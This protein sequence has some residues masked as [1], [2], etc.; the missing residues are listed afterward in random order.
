MRIR[1]FPLFNHAKTLKLKTSLLLLALSIFGLIAWHNFNQSLNVQ[2]KTY[3]ADTI[4]VTYKE[5]IDFEQKAALDDFW[6]TSTEIMSTLGDSEVSEIIAENIDIEQINTKVIKVPAGLSVEDMLEIY[7]QNPNVEAVEPDYY[8]KLDRVPNDPNYN[9]MSLGLTIAGAQKGWDYTVGSRD[10]VVAIVDS[11]VNVN[12]PDLQANMM[13]TGYSVISGMSYNVDSTGHGTGVAGTV[14]TVGNNGI[15]GVGINWEV[16]I[17]PVKIS[18]ASTFPMSNVVQGVLWAADN[19]ADIINMSLGS[20]AGSTSLKN[21][22]D[23]AY[24]KGVLLV[25]ASGNGGKEQAHYPAYYDNVMSVGGSPNGGTSGFGDWGE[26][27]NVLASTSYNTT[28]MNGGYSAMSGTSFASPQ[29][30][31]LAAL[32]KAYSPSLTNQQLQYYIEKGANSPFGSERTKVFGYGYY[33][34]Y[35]SLNLLAADMGRD[36][37]ANYP[38]ITDVTITAPMGQTTTFQLTGTGGNGT[39]SF[40]GAKSVSKDSQTAPSV[41]T[42]SVSSSGL[43]TITSPKEPGEFWVSITI[44]S[45]GLRNHKAVKVIATG[46]VEELGIATASLPAGETGKIYNSFE[47][48]AT[49]GNLPYTWSATDLPSGLSFTST[50]RLYGTPTAAGTFN[51]NFTVRDNAGKTASK[52]ISITISTSGLVTP[53]TANLTYTIPTGVIYNA[54]P[55][56]IT[57]PAPASGV[58]GLGAITVRYAGTGGTT[59]PES[60]T[61]PTNAG[62]YT[63]YAD[64]AEGTGYNAA[65]LTLGAYTIEKK[66]ISLSG[67]TV[68]AKTYDTTTTA[69]VTAA[70]FTGL[71][72]SQTLALDVDYTVSGAVFNSAD[73]GTGRTITGTVALIANSKTANYTLSSGALSIG[74]QTIAKKTINI[75]G[76]VVAPKVYD[77]TTTATVT[78]VSFS[79]LV[80]GQT[81]AISVDYTIASA[82]YDSPSVGSGK[83][84]TATVA[85]L[86]NAKANN[87]TLSPSG[88]GNLSIS[89][90]TI[91]ALPTP[92]TTQISYAI[93]TGIV[94]NASP[95]PITAPV[96]ASGVVG[97]GAITV[98]YA[99]TGGTTYPESTAAPTDAG[100]YNVYADI[101][102]GD[103]YN[104]AKLNL[105]VY[106]I[107]KKAIGLSGGTVASKTYNANTNANITAVSFTGLEGGQSLNLDDDYTI[108]DAEFNSADAGS[109]KTVTGTVALIANSKTANYT[110]SSGALSIGSQTIS[111]RNISISGATVAPKVYDSTTDADITAVSFSGLA[112]SQTLNLT[113]D[114]TVSGAAYDNADV[115]TS[116]PVTATVSLVIN[117]KTNNYNLSYGD[118]STTGNIIRPIPTTDE[119]DFTIPTGIIYNA[120]P[121]PITTPTPSDG[122]IGLGAITVKYAGA[123]S[124]I[125][126]ESATAPTDAGDYT[127]YADIAEGVNYSAV[128]LNLGAYTINQKTISISTVSVTPKIYDGTTAANI[129]SVSFSGLEGG[130]TLSIITDYSIV[131][132]QFND[133][134]AGPGR[135]VTGAV[136]LIANS[137]TANYTLSSGALS[138]GSQTIAK[139]PI[140]SVGQEFNVK[141]GF[142]SIYS[143]DLLTLLPSELAESDVSAFRIESISEDIYT[144]PPSI[145]GHTL[146]LPVA[147]TDAGDAQSIITIGFTSSN[148]DI[149]EAIISVN[150]TERSPVEIT[151][152][153]VNSRAYNGSPATITGTP[154]F[155]DTMS[156]TT[157][158][159]LAP[160]YT[161]KTSTDSVLGVAPTDAGNY[162]LVVSADGS[163]DYDVADLEISFTISKAN[164]T[165]TFTCPSSGQI[166]SAITLTASISSGLAGITFSSA[167]PAIATVSGN[168]LSLLD[169]GTVTI[170]AS[171]PGNSNI[172]AATST[173]SINVVIPGYGVIQHFADFDGTGHR[174]AIINADFIEFVR[175]IYEGEEL[176]LDHYTVSEGS[177]VITLHDT[178]LSTLTTGTHTFLAEFSNGSIV[179]LGIVILAGTDIGVPNTGI[180]G[181]LLGGGYLSTGLTLAVVAVISV[182]IFR[183]HLNL[184]RRRI[185]F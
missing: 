58:T 174:T 24:G 171:H 173:C 115:G 146:S 122:V 35:K 27:L 183:R 90:Q 110:L 116:K 30:A 74:S 12:H 16:S 76:G 128:K 87:Y 91:T 147:N 141:S 114:Y 140:F 28:N 150:V 57:T 123:G 167:N 138:I 157:I 163:G 139:A 101:A 38:D 6:Y 104:S 79:G 23:Y 73:A 9:S 83:T 93:P 108:S 96:P 143:F 22:M 165:I 84:V 162:K 103:N 178:F 19:G 49:G 82:T 153:S 56:P 129:S 180:I 37:L 99:G 59:Y 155:T 125:Y 149:T 152:V 70:S 39:Y 161:W 105:G 120:S 113:T 135:T 26:K 156:R 50:G 10:V 88:S 130:Q 107:E 48:T 80:G 17:L 166:N 69:S 133:A 126:P 32:L 14:G 65:K 55:R 136:A 179:P 61:A 112:G 181:F 46:T 106:T 7:S 8:M 15:G 124:T 119:I 185:R 98:H 78:A 43:L 127:V 62:S 13:P 94:Y 89:G 85:L 63:V 148:Y 2:A 31:G 100:N 20:S 42:P 33:D 164:Q 159:T 137:K 160:I 154:I 36:Q 111:K 4:L 44:A 18:S 169:T 21:A 75:S 64:I 54:S 86:S 118:L 95:R 176:H 45:D 34:I 182:A 145:S 1:R 60:A 53:T 77:G 67:G 3:S 177:T 142:V 71:V 25:A 168:T 184:R 134:N 5:G 52:T 170:T 97:L 117:S 29:I 11:G 72:G 40:S 41:I 47:I 102:V 81:L 51:I 151:G 68:G 144:A 131:D 158:G 109:D 121:R 132:A 92:T 172:N 66:A 175:L